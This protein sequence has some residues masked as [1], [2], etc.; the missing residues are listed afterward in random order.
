MVAEVVEAVKERDIKM[1]IE[2]ECTRCES[3]LA[4]DE[5]HAGKKIN[6][7]RCNTEVTIPLVERILNKTVCVDFWGSDDIEKKMQEKGIEDRAFCPFKVI[8][9]SVSPQYNAIQNSYPTFV[10]CAEK[11]CR[12]WNPQIN[13]CVFVNWK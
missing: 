10:R 5:E 11:K 8:M 4:V 6:C 13:D 1:K 2:F 7:P 3:P 9:R 12:L